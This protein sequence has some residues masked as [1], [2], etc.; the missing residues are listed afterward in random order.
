MKNTSAE[1]CTLSP[2]EKAKELY[3]KYKSVY[4]HEIK[5][6]ILIAIDEICEAIKRQTEYPPTSKRDTLFRYAIV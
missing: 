5:Q 3:D 1:H 4:K 2:K 6:Y